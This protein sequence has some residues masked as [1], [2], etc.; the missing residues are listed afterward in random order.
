[1]ATNTKSLKILRT[2]YELGKNKKERDKII[3]EMI[4]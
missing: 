1:M 2:I 3:K 4:I